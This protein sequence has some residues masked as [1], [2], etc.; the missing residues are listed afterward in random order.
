[1]SRRGFGRRGFVPLIWA[2]ARTE[3]DRRIT[4]LETE[5]KQRGS[6][7]F[8]M[9]EPP[10]TGVTRTIGYTGGQLFQVYRNRQFKEMR[11]SVYNTFVRAPNK[12]LSVL[13]QKWNGASAVPIFSTLNVTLNNVG[14]ITGSM[15]TV[16]A[17]GRDVLQPGDAW[18]VAVLCDQGAQDCRD[19]SIELEYEDWVPHVTQR[20]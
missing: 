5:T 13:L 9:L 17:S 10:L 20:G 19:L 6:E 2:S 11:V 3:I 7:K 16:A 14:E 18:S 4:R 8:Y 12:V 1:M 15:S